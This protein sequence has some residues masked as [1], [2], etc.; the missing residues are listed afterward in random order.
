M[1]LPFTPA[2][3]ECW[4]RDGVQISFFNTI[5]GHWNVFYSIPMVRI[6]PN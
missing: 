4:K 6:G 2:T 5:S 1:Q 3:L